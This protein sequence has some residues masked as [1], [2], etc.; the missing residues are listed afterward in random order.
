MKIPRERWVIMRNNRTEILCGGA[1]NYYFSQVNQR[2]NDPIKTFG[3]SRHFHF[4]S[5]NEIGNTSVKTYASKACAM[6]AAGRACAVAAND[7][8]EAV[9]VIES[10]EIAD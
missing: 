9:R 7:D 5:V 2:W 6:N 8:I 1:F 3:G 10:I 4:K